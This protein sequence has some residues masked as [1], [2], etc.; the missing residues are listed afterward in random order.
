MTERRVRDRRQAILEA[1]TALFAQRGFSDTSMADIVEASGVATG[2]VC[3]CF[4]N[5]NAV[6]MAVSESSLGVRFDPDDS[7]PVPLTEAIETL[8]AAATDPRRSQI[9]SQVWAK[10]TSS[11]QLRSMIAER[12][13]RVCRWLARSIDRAAGDPSPAAQRRAELI[14]CGVSGVRIR[15]ASGVEID[16]EAFREELLAIARS[17]DG[18]AVAGGDGVERGG[19]VAVRQRARGGRPMTT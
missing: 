3:R 18:C 11:A 10:A 9:S 15:V 14:V 1:A 5:K 2:T 12:H 8:L 4:D 19:E 17:Y 13:I 7:T 6:V 16:A